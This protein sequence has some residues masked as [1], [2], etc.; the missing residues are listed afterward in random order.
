[1][2]KILK[3]DKMGGKTKST[4]THCLQ[5]SANRKEVEMCKTYV[6]TYKFNFYRV[7]QVVPSLSRAMMVATSWVGSS[8]GASGA[9]SRTFPAFAPVS[10]SSPNGYWTKSRKVASTTTTTTFTR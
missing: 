4:K 8:A 1:M 6:Y 3:N 5:V 2:L 9:Q 10:Q 7:I